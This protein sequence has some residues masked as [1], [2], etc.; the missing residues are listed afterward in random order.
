MRDQQVRD[1][2]GTSFLIRIAFLA[3]HPPDNL[4]H[5]KELKNI[6]GSA[7]AT[8]QNAVLKSVRSKSSTLTME[9]SPSRNGKQE[10]F[11]M[12]G[13][14]MEKPDFLLQIASKWLLESKK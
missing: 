7:T 5:L 13:L 6:F 11:M 10:I 1:F 14:N 9:L 8:L 2:A 12:T 4:N 3:M